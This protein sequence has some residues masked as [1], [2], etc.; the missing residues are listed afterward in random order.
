MEKLNDISPDPVTA[1]YIKIG[2]VMVDFASNDGV[3]QTLEGDVKYAKGDAILTGV[4]G[5]HWPVSRAHFDAMYEPA[6]D[7]AHGSDRL[8][9][10]KASAFIWAKQMTEPFTVC[11]ASGDI[12]TGKP[13]DWLTQYQDGQQGIVEDEIFRTTYQRIQFKAL[14]VIMENQEKTF[15]HFLRDEKINLAAHERQKYHDWKHEGKI[16]GGSWLGWIF[17]TLFKTPLQEKSMW[18]GLLGIFKSNF[19]WEEQATF[20][21]FEKD[22]KNFDQLSNYYGN[23]YRGSFVF[24]YLTG[25]LAVLAALVPVGFNFEERFGEQA[26]EYGLLATGVELLLILLILLI[27][28]IGGESSH[29]KG[30]HKSKFFRHRWHEKWLEYRSLAERFRYMEIM[31]PLGIDPREKALANAHQDGSW[32]NA[33]Y[34]YRLSEIKTTRSDDMPAYLKMLNGIM[35]EQMEYHEKNAGKMERIHHRLHTFASLLFVGTLFS[36]LAHFFF[37]QVMLTLLSGFMPA[38]AASMHGILA[39]GEFKKTANISERMSVQ[40]SGLIKR[41]VGANDAEIRAVVED[42]HGMVTDDVQDWKAIF[43]DKNV[44]LG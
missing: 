15:E 34:A 38:L 3:I 6:G 36:C 13:G 32:I 26:H 2:S 41:L 35:E 21:A 10:K 12:L 43:I 42:L 27:Y 16:N 7:F 22:H 24:N 9:R 23:Q 17:V 29:G 14:R 1:R 8:Y 20:P 11:L 25:A 5:E 30:A 39:N 31:Y 37:H 4:A 19:P 40:I 18:K 28:Q 33:Y 44:P